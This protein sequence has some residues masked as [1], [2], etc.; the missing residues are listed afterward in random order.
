MYLRKPFA[1]AQR[2]QYLTSKSRII[3]IFKYISVTL[4]IVAAIL[5]LSSLLFRVESVQHAIAGYLTGKIEEAYG[6]PLSIERLRIRNLDE[7]ILKGV[8]IKDRSNDTIIF[9]HEATAHISP[10]KLSEGSIQINTL[11]FAAP[12]IR[13]NRDSAGGPLNIQFLID[14]LEKKEESESKDI[15]L[16]INQFIVYDGQFHYDIKNA[17]HLNNRLDPNHIALG[18]FGCNISL[19]SLRSDTLS[20]QI[21]SI[22]G[23]EKS[24]LELSGF[25]AKVNANKNSIR[26]DNLS[27]EFPESRLES[28]RIELM[29]DSAGNGIPGINGRLM[30][31]RISMSDF[32]PLFPQIPE[33]T[34]ELTLEID[35]KSDSKETTAAL[36]LSTTDGLITMGASLNA[37]DL[38]SKERKIRISIDDIAIEN[39]AARHAA[40]F[41]GE[42]ILEAIRKAGEMHISGETEFAGNSAN[43]RATLLTRNGSVH[44]AIELNENGDFTLTA[45]CDSVNIGLFAENSEFGRCDIKT[46]VI[47]NKNR[48]NR[49]AMFYGDI[50]KFKYSG[51]EYSPI[52]FTG[53]A[54]KGKIKTHIAADDPNLEA[55]VH[56][57]HSYGSTNRTTVSMQVDSLIPGRLGLM[58]T[59]KELYSFQFEGEYNDYGKG[60]TLINA[61]MRNF[62]LDDGNTKSILRNMHICDNNSE[63]QRLLAVNSDFIEGSVFGSYNYSDLLK[64]LRRM[65]TTHIPLLKEI[66]YTEKETANNYVFN[67]NIRNSGTA[68][69]IMRLPIEINGQSVIFGTCNDNNN[70][71][72]VNATLRDVKLGSNRL[73][74]LKLNAESDSKAFVLAADATMPQKKKDSKDIDISLKS[75]VSND[76]VNSSIEWDNKSSRNRMKGALHLNAALYKEKNGEIGIAATIK[77]DSI[78]HN[79]SIWYISEGRVN[80]GLDNVRINN[81][82]LYNSTQH[83]KIN[84]IA[85]KETSDSLLLSTKN[86]EIATIMEFVNFNT[87]R[88]SGSATGKAMLRGILGKPWIDGYF[89]IKDFTIDGGDMGDADFYIGWNNDKKAII[90]DCD[91]DNGTSAV[92]NVRGHLSSANDTLG[93][94]VTANNMNVDFIRYK[95]SDYVSDIKGT[96]S[97]KVDIKGKWRKI[98]LYGAMALNCSTHVKANNTAYRFDGD[99]IR[100][101]QGALTFDNCMITDRSGNHGWLTGGFYH[102]HFSNWRCGLNVRAENLLAYDTRTFDQFPFY[103]TVYASGNASLVSDDNG[104]NLKAE[105]SSG[106]NSQ[107][108]YNSSDT[109]GIRDNSFVTF[110]DNSPKSQKINKKENRNAGYSIMS[111]LNLDFIL[112]I[113][114]S[115]LLKVYTNMNTDD[116]IDI[117]ASGPIHAI[118]DENDGFSMKGHLDLD[119]GTYKFTV[120]DIFPKEF[121]I[122]RGSSLIFNGDP[123][124][125]TLD[126]KTKYLVPSA[127]LSD[128]TT[129]TSKRKSVKVNCLMNIGGTLKSPVLNFDLEL[130]EGNEEERELLASVANTQEQKNMQFIYLLGI[131]KFYTYDYNNNGNSQSSSAMESLISNTLSGQINNMLGQII[132]NG[133]WDI[134]GNFST[135]ERGWNSM[136]VEGMLEGRLLDNRLLINGNFGYRENPVANRNFIGDFEIQWLLNKKGNIS[137]KAYSKTNDRYFSKTNLTT[138]GAGIMLRHD[139][140]K[141]LWWKKEKKTKNNKTTY[142][143]R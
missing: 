73:N 7:I 136:E 89:D 117:Y 19:K 30:F 114:E 118:Y 48:N 25:R 84:G 3:K 24:G 126:L 83:L 8:L 53:T 13:L 85:G 94:T 90:L 105:L 61:L 138:Q 108:V 10:H 26:V 139:F 122:T 68:S 52:S 49:T 43:G 17:A 140:N 28:E 1:H 63:D 128:L 129:E 62:T 95:L 66:N 93:I 44:A 120:Q 81:L 41:V 34:P 51:Y 75:T 123:Y 143:E 65:A 103:G 29:Q 9:A 82:Q 112:D 104:F 35:G 23:K 47:G 106:P 77:P 124:E 88:F 92:S 109:G 2:Q 99:S 15:N 5:Y 50:T 116:Y 113:N 6:I 101:S 56:L 125:A 21:R 86:L 12:D 80:G 131:G 132:D 45:E 22:R 97:G 91:I 142:R 55:S 64:S 38:Y 32:A 46:T 36:R 58:K 69:R 96:C 16:R 135:S 37:T 141:W 40:P 27:T 54:E 98:D 87:L 18:D 79:D 74:H 107:F 119:R 76:T 133:N 121:S 20:I 59:G 71:F 60:R 67:F 111:R 137:L 72:R 78:T 100:F 33:S 11:T 4:A 70:E 57:G 14:N 31:E 130:P 110:T 127:S 115:M 39:G 42:S 102:N 134:S